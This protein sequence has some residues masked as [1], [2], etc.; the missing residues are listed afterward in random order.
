MFSRKNTKSTRETGSCPKTPPR[1]RRENAELSPLS[2]RKKYLPRRSDGTKP[3]A[4]HQPAAR[5]AVGAQEKHPHAPNGPET[6][7]EN[8]TTTNRDVRIKLT[9][10]KEGFER[11]TENQLAAAFKRPPRLFKEDSCFYPWLPTPVPKVNFHLNFK[12]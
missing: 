7:T 9:R 5:A 12:F 10:F 1:R 2:L 6:K 11:D 4:A 8:A 3:P